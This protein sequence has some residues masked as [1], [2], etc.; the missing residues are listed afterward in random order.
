MGRP[1][2]DI[3]EVITHVYT[4]VENRGECEIFK[5]WTAGTGYPSVSFQGEDWIISNLIAENQ[6]GPRP[7]DFDV[8][9]LCRN[10]LCVNWEHI[11]YAPRRVNNLHETIFVSGGNQKLSWAQASEIREL[12][13]LG[14]KQKEI[15]E[16]YGVA[17]STINDIKR[18]RTFSPKALEELLTYIPARWLP[19]TF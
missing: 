18:E 17:Y 4:Q 12:L 5:G 15:A 7:E 16:S 13:D 2:R 8:L 19:S 11:R 10:K 9:H 14:Y 6:Y 3:E 1:A